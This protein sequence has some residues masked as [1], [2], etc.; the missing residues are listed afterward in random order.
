MA[1]TP[2]GCVYE[3]WVRLMRRNMTRAA[4]RPRPD[5]PGS[6]GKRAS[7]TCWQEGLTIK[8]GI[9]LFINRIL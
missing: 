5:A 8:A 2:G 3:A 6:T 7:K 4:F 9:F 1:P